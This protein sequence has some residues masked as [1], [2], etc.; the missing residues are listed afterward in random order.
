MGDLLRVVFFVSPGLDDADGRRRLPVRCIW[1][2]E[3]ATQ[4]LT[5]QS[6][7]AAADLNEGRWR[8]G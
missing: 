8:D 5:E 2:S 3:G 7:A 4:Q 1:I 6:V